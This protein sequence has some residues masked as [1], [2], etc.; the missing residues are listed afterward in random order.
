MGNSPNLCN[1]LRQI[2]SL[3]FSTQ[4]RFVATYTHNSITI[5]VFKP[6]LSRFIET[7]SPELIRKMFAAKILVQ[8]PRRWNNLVK[9]TKQFS[10]TAP[11]STPTVSTPSSRGGSS[12]F[13][14]LNSFLVGSAIGFG[15]CFYFIHQELKESNT[16]FENY[17]EKLEGRIKNLETK[18]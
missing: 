6:R 4:D 12:F 5:F 13:Q 7:A 16:K 9:A 11:V 1:N 10:T 3:L 15:S 2:F 17:L 18:K 8:Q 14:R